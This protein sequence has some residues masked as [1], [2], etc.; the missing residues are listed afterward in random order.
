MHLNLKLAKERDLS[1]QDIADLETLHTLMNIMVTV[2][3]GMNDQGEVDPDIRKK[4]RK[5]VMQMEYM[6]QDKWGF[7]RTFMRHTHYKRFEGLYD[8]Y[9][10]T[11][12]ETAH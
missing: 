3:E 1:D 8:K 5:L 12:Q 2:W 6:M 11:T 10:G 4:Y 7:P 9:E